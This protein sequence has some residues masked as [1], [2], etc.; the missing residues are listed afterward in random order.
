MSVTVDP[1]IAERRR[2]VREV[3]ARRRLRWIILVLGLLLGAGGAIWAVQSPLLDV[4]T[5]LVSGG[6]HADVA[7]HLASTGVDLGRPMIG[8]RT[9]RAETALTSDPWIRDADVDLQWPGTVLVTVVEHRP[10]AWVGGPAGWMLAAVDGAVV[11]TTAEPAPGEARVRGDVAVDPGGVIADPTVLS[12]LEFV[13]ALPPSL[14]TGVVV[15]RGERGVVASLGGVTVRLGGTDRPA[16][17]ARV[18][19]AI[20]ADGVPAGSLVDVSAPA[21]PAVLEPVP[22]AGNTQPPVEDEAAP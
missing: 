5:I 21:R 7:A 18:A 11:L 8:V 20:I 2:D 3:G 10:V 12:G 14:S 4:D 19:A 17:K 6:E 16:D 15:E 9:G 22:D 1:R 13:A